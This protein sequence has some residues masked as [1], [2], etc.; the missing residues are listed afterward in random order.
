MELNNDNWKCVV[1]FEETYKCSIK[2]KVKNCKT[3]RIIKGGIG[4]SGEG[5]EGRAEDGGDRI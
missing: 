1:G 3:G 4:S 5:E 2:G